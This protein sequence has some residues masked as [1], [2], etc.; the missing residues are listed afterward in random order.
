[1][2]REP[3]QGRPR[4]CRLDPL[5]RSHADADRP[6]RALDSHTLIEESADLPFGLVVHPWA[7]E[8]LTLSHGTPQPGLDPLHGH[9]PLKLREDTHHLKQGLAGWR[10]RVYALLVQV[11]IDALGVQFT[12][13]RQK[14]HQGPAKAIHRPCGHY[15]DLTPAHCV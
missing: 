5:H 8:T 10:A 13:D 6:S 3:R 2:A 15:I 12:E 14:M 4:R 9:R 1:M 7:T 11:Q